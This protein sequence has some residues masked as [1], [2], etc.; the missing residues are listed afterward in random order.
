[1]WKLLDFHKEF[2]IHG[3]TPP[4]QIIKASQEYQ[5][6]EDIIQ[7][8]FNDGIIHMNPENPARKMIQTKPFGYV[9]R[10]FKLWCETI[11]GIEKSDIPKQPTF[12]EKLNKDPNLE[13]VREIKGKA[14]KYKIKFWDHT[15]DDE[16]LPPL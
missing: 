8:F 15:A 9:F 14:I 10:K 3:N 6:K 2:S 12:K 7:R 5:A 11:E 4:D 13:Y 1:M 16:E